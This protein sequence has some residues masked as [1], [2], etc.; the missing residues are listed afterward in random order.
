MKMELSHKE[1]VMSAVAAHRI[2]WALSALVVLFMLMDA[3]MKLVQLAPAL[4]ATV[5]LGWPTGSVVPLGFL[6][7]CCTAL[8]SLPQTSVLGAIL[9]T[10]YLGGAVAS[11]A[12][13]GSPMLTHTLFGVYVGVLLWGGLY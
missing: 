12:R 3:A 13:V 10:G 11:H 8:Y 9:L 1:T 6:L 7:L 2:G 4:E 5:Q